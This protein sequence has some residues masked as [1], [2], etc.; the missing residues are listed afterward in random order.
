[1]LDNKLALTALT[2]VTVGLYGNAAQAVALFRDTQTSSN[3][4]YEKTWVSPVKATIDLNV[5][6][7]NMTDN[8]TASIWMDS[9]QVASGRFDLI[10]PNNPGR[11]E[12]GSTFDVEVGSQVRF[13]VEPT[14]TFDFNS[15]ISLLEEAGL[16]FIGERDRAF[17]HVGLNWKGDIYES[18]APYTQGQYWD[19]ANN[20]YRPINPDNGVQKEHSFGSFLH[21]SP[22]PNH[23]P[24]PRREYVRIPD[25]L[26]QNYAGKMQAFIETQQLSSTYADAIGS[27]AFLNPYEQ[28]CYYG[29]CT[30]VGLTERASE[31]AFVRGGQGFIP[32]H[33]EFIEVNTLFF[34][35]RLDAVPFECLIT[36]PTTPDCQRF[37]DRDP[38]GVLDITVLSPAFQHYFITQLDAEYNDWLQ[39]WFQNIDFMLTDP[40]GNQLGYRDGTWTQTG[41]IPGVFYT[42]TD[43]ERHFFIPQRLAGN[44]SLEFFGLCNKG[45]IAVL[46]DNKDGTLISGC[47]EPP[48][49]D[50]DP[51]DPDP[52]PSPKV[53]EPSM[54]LGIA[55]LGFLGIGNR[56]KNR[57]L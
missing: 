30:G 25:P 32:N 34:G 11:L 42:A 39:G 47:K 1:M 22:D 5:L 17:S 56:R 2:T 26:G 33:L 3:T 43:S 20:G 13:R 54:L 27:T 31:E 10:D 44:Y 14:G 50:P 37:A 49:T 41:N 45:A 4:T 9:Q 55:L 48:I 21:S 24:T 35:P 36:F 23:S 52:D 16:V 46:G 51:G 53:P 57:N 12:I 15:T 19:V 18:H 28:K 8:L 38:S 6:L 29:Q 40:Q 7:E